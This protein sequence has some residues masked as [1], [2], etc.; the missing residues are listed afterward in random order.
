M[1][2]KYKIGVIGSHGTGKSTAATHLTSILKQ[3]NP[4][5]SVVCL[6]ENVR[7][8]AKFTDG[9]LNTIEFQKLAM[10]DQLFRETSNEI[11]HDIIITDRTLL[12][13]L[14]YGVLERNSLPWEYFLLVRK[15]LK[16]F[17]KIYFI[18]PDSYE[19]KIAND[20]FRDTDLE[21]RKVV[22]KKFKTML[23]Y[24]KVA[25]TEIKSSEILTYDYLKD[26]Q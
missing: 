12:D 20:H 8:I 3:S 13:Y 17:K 9:K 26:L 10:A 23:R 1:N 18:R 7:R 11:L 24:G 5:K 19:D 2:N 25:Y 4:K 16:T 6:E 15:H 21:Y 14:V 22:D